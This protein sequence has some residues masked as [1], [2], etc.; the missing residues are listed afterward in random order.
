[1]CHLS[2]LCQIQ[3][4]INAATKLDLFELCVTFRVTFFIVHISESLGLARFVE[5]EEAMAV[6]HTLYRAVS[7]LQIAK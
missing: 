2:V 6:T 3:M 5:I 4:K 7:S 1:M